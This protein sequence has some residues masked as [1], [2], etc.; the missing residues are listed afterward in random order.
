MSPEEKAEWSLKGFPSFQIFIV[1]SLSYFVFV[2][3]CL[4]LQLSI[5]NFVGC[6]YAAAGKVDAQADMKK[7]PNAFSEVF[8]FQIPPPCVWNNVSSTQLC[9]GTA[10]EKA[11]D[12]VEKEKGIPDPK[13]DNMT[14]HTGELENASGETTNFEDI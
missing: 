8:S 2:F 13:M 6:V 3:F 1:L 4:T 14:E 9:F 7:N 11:C 10:A 5:T 12:G